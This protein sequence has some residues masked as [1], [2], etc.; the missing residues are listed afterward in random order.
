MAGTGRQARARCGDDEC[1]NTSRVQGRRSCLED[2]RRSGAPVLG[3]LRAREP[4]ELCR[5]D[6]GAGWQDVRGVRVTGRVPLPPRA[7]AGKDTGE[8]LLH[9]A[10]DSC[11]VLI[12]RRVLPDKLR[13]LPIGA[14]DE[15]P[16]G[17]ECVTGATPR[18]QLRCARRPRSA[19]S[20]RDCRSAG[21]R[22]QGRSPARATST[23]ALQRR[24]RRRL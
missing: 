22:C 5:W 11:H 1:T 6:L 20:P 2:H 7:P 4:H 23:R 8:A 12:A 17:H 19:R 9:A 3:F 14:C 16:V 15:D 18:A 13:T 10:H 24:P 21:R